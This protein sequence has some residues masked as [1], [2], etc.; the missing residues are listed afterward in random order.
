MLLAAVTSHHRRYSKPAPLIEGTLHR[1][2][3]SS[4]RALWF[5]GFLLSSALA[6]G[7]HFTEWAGQTGYGTSAH[8]CQFIRPVRFVLFDFVTVALLGNI[9]FFFKC[10]P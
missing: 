8:V 4:D 6:C 3:L 10:L 7:Q 1:T 2:Q 5:A 9:L